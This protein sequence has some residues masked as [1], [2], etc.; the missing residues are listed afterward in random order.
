MIGEKSERKSAKT[1]I[2]FADSVGIK[3]TEWARGGI[4]ERQRN[5][6]LVY[7]IAKRNGVNIMFEIGETIAISP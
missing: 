5:I 1:S 2:S 7:I 4:K 6:G 3:E